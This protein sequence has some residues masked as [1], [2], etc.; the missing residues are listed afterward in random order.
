ME[1]HK[2]GKEETRVIREDET[3]AKWENKKQGRNGMYPWQVVIGKALLWQV[4]Q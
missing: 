3:R 2:M 4:V 1:K